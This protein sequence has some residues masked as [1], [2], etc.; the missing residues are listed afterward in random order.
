MK[1]KAKL[2]VAAALLVTLGGP[3]FAQD[4]GSKIWYPYSAG[5]CVVPQNGNVWFPGGNCP[6]QV[7][8]L[9]GRNS[10]QVEGYSPSRHSAK[11][12]ALETAN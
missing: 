10:A 4:A 2:V 8:L 5:R 9:E 3:V 11:R 7:N 12:D 1:N 6:P